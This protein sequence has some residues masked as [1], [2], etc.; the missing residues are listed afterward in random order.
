MK[1]KNKIGLPVTSAVETDSIR[2]VKQ[3]NRCWA[4]GGKQYTTPSPCDTE[5]LSEERPGDKNIR[6]IWNILPGLRALRL[7][8]R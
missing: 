7:N 3:S 4:R 1:K 8:Q 6:A 5:I 2:S